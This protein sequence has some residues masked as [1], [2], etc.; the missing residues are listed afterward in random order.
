MF[1]HPLFT[2]HPPVLRLRLV[3]TWESAGTPRVMDTI[4]LASGLDRR[5]PKPLRSCRYSPILTG[6]FVD[7]QPLAAK[8][9]MKLD[10]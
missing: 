3:N 9:F 10:H 4:S 1:T 6:T 8:P 7:L 5:I 2:S